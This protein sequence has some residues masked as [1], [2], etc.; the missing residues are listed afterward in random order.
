VTAN[1]AAR[2]TDFASL[3]GARAIAAYLVISTHA[4]FESGLSLGS[5]PWAPFLARANFGVTVF[6]LLSGFLLSRRFLFDDST[7]SPQGLRGF[8]RRRA[9]RILPAYWLA[10]VGALTLFTVRQTSGAHW[11]YYLLLVH[12]YVAMR[13]DP[14]LSQMWTL[15]VEISF[16]AVLPLLFWISRKFGGSRRSQATGLV[17]AMVVAALVGNVMVH[18]IAGDNSRALLWMPL[19]LDWFALG[20]ALAALSVHQGEPARWQ[21]T[22]LGW[23]RSTATCWVVGLLL[24]WLSTLPLAGPRSLVALTTW[25]WTLRHYLFAG[26]AF[27]LLLPLVV[28]SETWP[29]RLLGNR[30]MSWLGEVSYGVYLWHLGLLLAIQRW[31]GYAPLKGHFA[32]LFLL[33]TSAATVVAALSWYL[34]ERPLLRRFS[35]SW[36][37]PSREESVGQQDRDHEQAQPLHADTAGQRMA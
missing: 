37:R 10:I 22:A 4:G 12:P 36:R 2:R 25:E 23:A 11:A 29:D 19:Y 27:F 30:V 8:W 17:L 21:L 13:I 9:T 14:T 3:N 16:Y 18:V 26:S 35:Q 1:P 32:E 20:I 34:V 28:G 33:T 5:S 6:F 31:L 24:F 7:L 15:A